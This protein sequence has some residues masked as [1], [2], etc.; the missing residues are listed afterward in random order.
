VN[1]DD[2]SGSAVRVTSVPNGQEFAHLDPQSI[3][4]GREVT[5]PPPFPSR[6]TVIDTEG[7]GSRGIRIEPQ[8]PS[9]WSTLIA[10]A[11]VARDSTVAKIPVGEVACPYLL[12]PQ[13]ST[14]PIIRTAHVSKPFQL[15]AMLTD[16]K[17]PS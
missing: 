12:S 3:P 8:H 7:S 10:H 4:A 17:E 15:T 1:A 16:L 2:E 14:L 9:H 5:V 11:A 6:A 13:H